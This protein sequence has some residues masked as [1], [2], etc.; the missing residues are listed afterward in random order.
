M[1]SVEL[2]VSNYQPTCDTRHAPDGKRRLRSERFRQLLDV[3]DLGARR[4]A[5]VDEED[6]DSGA[7]G[8]GGIWRCS[9][10]ARPVPNA[11]FC[12]PASVT[13]RVKQVIQLAA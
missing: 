7:A 12:V 1:Y 6:V 10:D 4:V 13:S 2:K 11:V 3:A 5:V 9:Q 8:G